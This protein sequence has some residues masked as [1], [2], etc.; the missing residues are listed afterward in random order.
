MGM[1]FQILGSGSAGNCA[2]L[3]TDHARILVD[4]GFSARR[5]NQLIREA[6]ADL[7]QIDAVFITHEHSDHVAGIEGLKRYPNIELFA[8]AG[9][10]RAVQNKLEYRPRWRIFE[11]GARFTFRDLEI[12]SFHIPHDA[13]E[14]VGYTFTHGQGREGD[15]FSSPRRIA[16]LS[17]MGHAPD[18]IRERIRE[19][20]AVV[21]ESNH[22]PRLLEADHRRPWSTK[23]RIAGRHGHLSNELACELLASVAS[24]RW[25]HIVLTHLSRDC[26][27]L[28]AVEQTFATLRARLTCQFAIVPPG[29]GTALVELR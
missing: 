10:A 22:C 13:Q 5:L 18:H 17:D 3:L 11:T 14:P 8:N 1:R 29:G 26:N 25:Q 23:Q 12:E 9:T 20:D 16:W 21:M 2:L 7:S 19:A 6:G 27:T 28:D 15:L 24:P 4:A